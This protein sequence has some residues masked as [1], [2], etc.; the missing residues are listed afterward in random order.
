LNERDLGQ[1]PAASVRG[2]DP[3]LGVDEVVAMKG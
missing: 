2:Q 1:Q 3:G